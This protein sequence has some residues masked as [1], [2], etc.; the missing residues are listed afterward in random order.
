MT[1]AATRLAAR[2]RR[3]GLGAPGR[4]LADAHLPLAPL[5]SDLGAAVN[6]LLGIMGRPVRDVGE[7]L[8][9]PDGLDRLIEQLDRADEEADDGAG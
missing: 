8:E 1:D 7:L 3:R 5:L 9:A 4:L 2:L 6:P